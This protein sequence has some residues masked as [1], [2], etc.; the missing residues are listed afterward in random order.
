MLATVRTAETSQTVYGVYT[1]DTFSATLLSILEQAVG[2]I[3][4]N[5]L[6]IASFIWARREMKATQRDEQRNPFESGAASFHSRDSGD[7]HEYDYDHDLDDSVSSLGKSG[8]RASYSSSMRSARFTIKSLRGD[9]RIST[10]PSLKQS[11]ADAPLRSIFN[12]SASSMSGR[13]GLERTN[14][15]AGDSSDAASGIFMTVEVDVSEEDFGPVLPP[16]HF[17]ERQHRRLPSNASSVVITSEGNSSHHGHG[18]SHHGRMESDNNWT[19]ML[20]A[21]SRPRP[22]SLRASSRQG[23]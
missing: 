2:I 3:S 12:R 7:H 16:A 15:D 6:P 22:P 14:G 10:A 13:P 21:G 1:F 11:L 8:T 19:T 18:L 9:D 17:S 5:V 4:A 23:Y 20:R